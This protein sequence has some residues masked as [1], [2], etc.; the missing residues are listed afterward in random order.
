MQIISYIDIL[1][2]IVTLDKSLYPFDT[3]EGNKFFVN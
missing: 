2:L 3:L 1:T